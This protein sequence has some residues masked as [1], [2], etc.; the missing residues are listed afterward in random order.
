MAKAIIHSYPT[1]VTS[2]RNRLLLPMPD[3][4]IP[5]AADSSTEKGAKAYEPKEP[6]VIDPV[7]ADATGAFTLPARDFYVLVT[8]VDGDAWFAWGVNRAAVSNPTGKGVFCPSGVTTPIYTIPTAASDL[9]DNPKIN[10]AIRL[11]G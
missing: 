9:G 5:A 11:D 2:D 8:M 4:L 6:L 10:C 7:T 3:R 1:T